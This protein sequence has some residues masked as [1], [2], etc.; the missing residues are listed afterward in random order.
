MPL[1]RPSAVNSAA[2]PALVQGLPLQNLTTQMNAF[3]P[4]KSRPSSAYSSPS[5]SSKKKKP[6]RR[7]ESPASPSLAQSDT[8]VKSSNKGSAKKSKATLKNKLDASL[9]ATFNDIHPKAKAQRTVLEHD[10]KSLREA[11]KDNAKVKS[12]SEEYFSAVEAIDNSRKYALLVTTVSES[13]Q[14][15]EVHYDEQL[16]NLIDNTVQVL[17]K[18]KPSVK[19]PEAWSAASHGLPLL[20]HALDKPMPVVEDT[21]PVEAS[22][23]VK[24]ERP[25]PAEKQQQQQ[26][27]AYPTAESYMILNQWYMDFRDCPYASNEDVEELARKTGLT[28]HKVRKWL[29]NRRLR[30]KSNTVRLRKHH[31]KRLL[32]EMRQKNLQKKEELQRQQNQQQ[33]GSDQQEKLENQEQPRA[34]KDTREEADEPDADVVGSGN[35]EHQA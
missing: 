4:V 12:A 11:N 32:N 21:E 7:S 30:D 22:A 5:S 25:Q 26:G 3:T 27:P 15:I 33:H 34:S 29:G 13:R 17:V 28:A 14:S 24:C 19:I 9:E 8:P 35:T 16:M 23:S 10:I 6:Q 18:L 2:N 31:S 20:P 1:L